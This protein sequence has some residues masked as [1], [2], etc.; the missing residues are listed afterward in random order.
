[1]PSTKFFEGTPFQY[2]FLMLTGKV[3]WKSGIHKEGRTQQDAKTVPVPHTKLSLKTQEIEYGL[4]ILL[5]TQVPIASA[6]VRFEISFHPT[7]STLKLLHF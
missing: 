3:N 7:F 6:R 2:V 4:S 5:Y 1:M